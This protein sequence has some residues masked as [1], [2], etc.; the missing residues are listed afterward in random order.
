MVMY[1][2]R[3][4]DKNQKKIYSTI[5]SGYVKCHYCVFMSVSFRL[6]S[7][8]KLSQTKGPTLKGNFC[9][10]SAQFYVIN[11]LLSFAT[12]QKGTAKQQKKVKKSKAST[13]APH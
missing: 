9:S 1:Y 5:H 4:T 8:T 12:S 13:V 10:S 6:F 11:N 3:I 2:Q 7:Q